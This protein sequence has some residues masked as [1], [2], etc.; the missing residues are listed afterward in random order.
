MGPL[1][2]WLI[3]PEPRFA[4]DSCDGAGALGANVHVSLNAM[5]L[6]EMCRTVAVRAYLFRGR[7]LHP[8][9]IMPMKVLRGYWND[10][11]DL[12]EVFAGTPPLECRFCL[13]ADPESP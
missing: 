10:L 9:L 8:S 5:Q 1:G 2:T 7:M 11:Q 6:T 3:F 13:K 12:A 4:D